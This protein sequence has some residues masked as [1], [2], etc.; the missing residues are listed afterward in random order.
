MLDLLTLSVGEGAKYLIEC[1]RRLNESLPVSEQVGDEHIVMLVV[2]DGAI[3]HRKHH[4]GNDF[5]YANF[6]GLCRKAMSR[7]GGSILPVDCDGA[8]LA[9]ACAWFLPDQAAS[10][11]IA[12]ST[13]HRRLQRQIGLYRPPWVHEQHALIAIATWEE[14]ACR[15][16]KLAGRGQTVVAKEL[17]D[18]LPCGMRR[19]ARTIGMHPPNFA[20]ATEELVRKSQGRIRAVLDA[21]KAKKPSESVQYVLEGIEE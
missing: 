7:R 15:L 14:G 3:E 4:P 21:Y 11:V 9:L 5:H 12:A 1:R 10:A 6:S 8:V 20:V 19:L 17:W 16:L 2:Q 18:E 13:I